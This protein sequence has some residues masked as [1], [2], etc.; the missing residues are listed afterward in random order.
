[1]LGNKTKQFF[2]K[3]GLRSETPTDL[4]T[5]LQKSF[6]KLDHH[7]SGQETLSV[8]QLEKINTKVTCTLCSMK[9]MLY[10]DAQRKPKDE[11]ID[12]LISLLHRTGML[13]EITVMLKTFDTE[14][15]KDSA[16]IWNYIVRR[17]EDNGTKKYLLNH[18][19]DIQNSLL[20]GY[21]EPDTVFA[22]GS[23]FQEMLKHEV[24]IDCLLE[25]KGVNNVIFQLM[26]YG[27]QED[28]DIMSA[29]FASLKLII[30]KHKSPLTVWLD[31]NY[32]SFFVNLNSLISSNNRIMR[33]QSLTLL[34]KIL[35]EREHFNIM[36][37]YSE[38]REN[39]KLIMKMLTDSSKAIQFEAFQIFKIFVANPNKP[40]DVKIVLWKNKNRL[41][42][43]LG[44][45]LEDR[46]DSQFCSEK[47]LVMKHLKALEMPG[48]LVNTPN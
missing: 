35:L 24:F 38:D 25:V 40:Y 27:Q 41:I 7:T 23:I 48:D 11:H 29:A 42:E 26:R 14:G 34:G 43:Y 37:R 44:T 13:L 6:R 8:A 19:K 12:K 16:A 33:C 3:L 20:D 15:K 31:E 9:F 36:T 45:F 32:T 21:S 30:T 47:I 18:M 39:L 1:M 4:V 22:A 46:D 10:G 28:F 17:C 2:N 5:S